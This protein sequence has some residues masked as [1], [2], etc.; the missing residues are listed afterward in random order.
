MHVIVAGKTLNLKRRRDER[1]RAA[2]IIRPIAS[3]HV[4]KAG[5]ALR[6]PGTGVM[7]TLHV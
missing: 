7:A 4:S 6:L 2:I 3:T 1:L 5:F